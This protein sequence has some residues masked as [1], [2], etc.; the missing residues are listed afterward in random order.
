M[1]RCCKRHF[2]DL[3]NPAY[4]NFHS[5]KIPN[6]P[7]LF[8]FIEICVLARYLLI[9]DGQRTGDGETRH[10]FAGPFF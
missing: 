4:C 9:N 6:K 2:Q 3:R 10:G 1:C 5:R 7:Y 8:V